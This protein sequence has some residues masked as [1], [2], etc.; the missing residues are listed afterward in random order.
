[1]W[2]PIIDGALRADVFETIELIAKAIH[3]LAG[4]ALADVERKTTKTGRNSRRHAGDST[5]SAAKTVTREETDPS[6]ANGS[7]GLAIMF[8]YLNR[9]H[10]GHGD[11]QTAVYFLEQAIE[12]VAAAPMNSS[13]YG[14]VTGVAWAMAH[15]R[16]SVF[17]LDDDATEMVDSLLKDGLR[18]GPWR[19]SYDLIDGLVGFGVYALEQLPR[20]VGIECLA[21]VVDRLDEIAERTRDGITWFT[22]PDLLPDWQRELC[23]NGYYNLG[24]AHGMPGVIAFL[25]QVYALDERKLRGFRKVRAKTR[26]LLQGAVTWLLAQKGSD[27]A[28]SLFPSWIAPGSA[29]TD[30][31]VAWCYGDLGIA[32]ALLSAGNCLNDANLK[33]DAVRL[34]R[35]VAKRS[36]DQSGVKDCGFCHGAAGVGHL[37]NRMFQATGESRLKDAAY[38]WFQRTLEMRHPERGVAGFAAFR[39]DHWSDEVGIL[40][41]AAGIALA[42]LAT[43]TPIEPRWDRMLL[44]SFPTP[45][46]LGG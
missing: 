2:D 36:F 25:A 39:P 30:S 3:K 37:F 44:A 5:A 14:G 13:L 23:P 40:E 1:M 46:R 24:V 31:R 26:P 9:A 27:N 21:H 20:T 38:G 4:S 16:G 6:L 18:R 32:A 43:V 41:G 33:S 10:G 35:H 28:D 8:A 17:E 7:A 34:A 29:R 15:L 45:R 11:K 12:A 19:G 42:L 22:S